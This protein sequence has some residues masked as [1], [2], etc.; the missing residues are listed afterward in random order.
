MATNYKELEEYFEN[1]ATQHVY[2]KNTPEDKHF[3]RIDVEEYLTNIDSVEYPFLSLERAE[4]G[5]SSPNN[6][7]ISK[8]RTVAF[9]IVN[10]FDKDDFNRMNEIYDETEEVA[11]DIINR[12]INDTQQLN[13]PKLLRDVQVSS[14]ALQHLPPN[15]LENYCGVRVT[16]GIQSRYEKEV[17]ND[18]W[19]DLP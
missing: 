17:D 4:F 9:M 2:I 19:K 16:M 8:N 13:F 3:Y 7:N 5:L 10:K 12:I 11:E 18:K 14:I 15:P 6:D 1:L